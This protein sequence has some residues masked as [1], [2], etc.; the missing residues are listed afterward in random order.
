MKKFTKFF[1]L[2]GVLF[3]F[4]ILNAEIKEIESL[5]QISNEIVG[6]KTDKINKKT[7]KEVVKSEVEK[8]SKTDESIVDIPEES[9]TRTVDK[10]SIV[11]IYERKMKDKIAYKEGSD[12]PFTGVFGV[13]ID[14][15]IESYEEYKNGVLDG[16]TAYFAKGKQVKLLS[17]MYTK[18]KLN[19]QQKS[20]YENGKLK[21]I[22][23][24]SNDRIN[25]IESYDRNGKLLHKSI[26]ENGTG[27]WKFYW[28]N[29][30]VSE[31]GKYKAWRKDGVWKKYRED[32][33]LDTVIKYDNGRLLSEKWQ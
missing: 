24:Y 21:S 5:D 14:D 4:S 26:F 8:T 16:E 1:I 19:G 18:G 20:Y 28:S 33:S 27:D 12:I 32:G 17:E 25:G 13:V 15:K 23:Y 10:N 9:A 2:A 29:G 11:D 22:V 31:E 6:G 7:K 3:N 30:K